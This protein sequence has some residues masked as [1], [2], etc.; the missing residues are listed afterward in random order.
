LVIL[1]RVPLEQMTDAEHALRDAAAEIPAEVRK[2]LDSPD[3]L[4]D[5]D[6]KAIIQ[7]GS[8][9]LDRFQPKPEPKDKS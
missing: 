7:I 9:S 3:K 8:K 4:T 2:R 6:R 5:D 1:D